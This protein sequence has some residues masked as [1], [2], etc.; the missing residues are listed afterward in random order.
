VPAA[1]A[2]GGREIGP[3]GLNEATGREVSGMGE[4]KAKTANNRGRLMN[5]KDIAEEFGLTTRDVL[6][7][8]QMN[9]FPW[10]VQITGRKRWFRRVDVNKWAKENNVNPG[11][12]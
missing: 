4:A 10:P 7:Y 11:P 2:G 6:R 9:A 12:S 5:Q 3:S 1:L 8:V